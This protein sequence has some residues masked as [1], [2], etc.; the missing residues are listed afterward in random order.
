MH[1]L[2]PGSRYDSWFFESHVKITLETFLA[3]LWEQQFGNNIVDGI[4][5]RETKLILLRLSV[6]SS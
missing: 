1:Q 5:L 3:V 2:S 4:G 6:D